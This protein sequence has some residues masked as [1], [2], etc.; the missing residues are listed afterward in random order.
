M[1]IVEC[2]VKPSLDFANHKIKW[3]KDDNEVRQS[4]VPPFGIPTTYEQIVD[5]KTG[6]LSLIIIYPTI[7]SDC[8]LYR[9]C[10][11]D[12]NLQ[13]VDEISHLVYKIFN[14]PPHIPLESIDIIE[15]KNRVVFDSYLSDIYAEEGSR[16]IR[17]NC[18]I[19]Q[20]NAQSEI[21]WYKN[22]EELLTDCHSRKYRFT[23][24][25]NRLCLEIM[26]VSW[27]DAGAYEC[28]VKNIHNEISSKCNIYV[29]ERQQSSTPKGKIESVENKL[30]KNIENFYRNAR[31]FV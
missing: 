13:K 7:N 5:E 26:N 29:N 8:G 11:L 9:C 14:P 10:V 21:K 12:R 4:L 19:S 27:N 15:N 18:K 30:N 17:L 1:L 6:K 23:K 20:C 24:S 28:R 16:T 31:S 22:N 2:N 3:Y 25:Y